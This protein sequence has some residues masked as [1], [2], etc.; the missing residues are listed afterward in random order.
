MADFLVLYNASCL[1]KDKVHTALCV[2]EGKIIAIGSDNDI[3]NHYSSHANCLNLNGRTIWPG[4]CDS[5]LHLQYL[6]GAIYAIDCETNTLDECLQR[7]AQR[8]SATPS[9]E[10][11]RGH[12]WNHNRWDENAYGDADQ[13]DAVSADHPAFLTSKSLHASWANSKALQLAGITAQTPDPPGGEIQHGKDGSPTG[14]LLESASELVSMVIPEPSAQQLAQDFYNLQQYLIRSG[15]TSVHDFDGMLTLEALQLL[16]NQEKLKLRVLK[17]MPYL[18]LPSLIAKN[19][20][21]NDGDDILR[22]GSLKLFAD[23]A[24]G[25]QTAAMID[26]YEGGTSSG[27]LLLSADEIEQKGITALK[28]G[29]GLTIHA[30]G[31]RANREVINGFIR[32]RKYQQQH[33][34]PKLPL[35]IEHVQCISVDDLTRLKPFQITAS[36]QPLHC[37]SDMFIVDRYWGDR[38]RFAFP[39]SSLIDQDVFFVFGS[40][41]PVESFNP[42]YGIHAAVTRKRHNSTAGYEGWHPEQKISLENAL[43][44]YSVNPAI[45]SGMG[46]TSGKIT[47]GAPADLLVLP[48]DP[49]AIPADDL[50]KITPEITLVNG[51]IVHQK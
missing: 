47:I 41:A 1:I 18:S 28:A 7:V 46:S 11:L 34:L 48:V 40:D 16:H 45:L 22:M 3:L 42:F 37:P 10:W 14:I 39:F 44:G 36:V 8:S 6:S 17:N 5:H 4:L 20:K 21:G 26:P 13:L 23:G 24:L 33:N 12:G 31:D 15:I 9:G 25:P 2:N 49:F 51:E 35:R 50:Y 29:W 27:L 32:I 38:G 43:K 30:I 19:I